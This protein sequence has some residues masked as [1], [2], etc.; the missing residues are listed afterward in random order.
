M[1]CVASKNITASKYTPIK[2][3]NRELIH[4][5]DYQITIKSAVIERKY[6]LSPQ[7][8]SFSSDSPT[9]EFKYQKIRA[10]QVYDRIEK[11]EMSSES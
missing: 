7:I 11:I 5:Y 2:Y 4:I 1:Y 3:K 9:I 6:N 8:K 10:H